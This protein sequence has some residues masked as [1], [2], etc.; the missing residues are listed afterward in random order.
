M[1]VFQRSQD[2]RWCAQ[3]NENGKKKRRY[4]QTKTEAEAF[5]RERVADSCPEEQ[6]LSMGE[7]V[8]LYFRSN[9]DKHPKTRRLVRT[10]STSLPGMKNQESILMV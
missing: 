4:F 7:L 9:P 8:A 10:S 5:E 2:G 6:A 3:W 1:S